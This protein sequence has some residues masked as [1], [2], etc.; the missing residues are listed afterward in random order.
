MREDAMRRF[1][2]RD[3]ALYFGHTAIE[4][5]GKD[6]AGRVHEGVARGAEKRVYLEVDQRAYYGDVSVALESIR[7]AG[8]LDVTFIT[9][10]QQR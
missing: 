10:T 8:I 4:P 6:F 5:G 9:E 2:T 7:H 3:G 1:V